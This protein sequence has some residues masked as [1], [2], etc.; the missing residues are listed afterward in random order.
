MN[1]TRSKGHERDENI[2]ANEFA[3]PPIA[4]ATQQA[5]AYRDYY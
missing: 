2:G 4:I 3:S 1:A 5:N